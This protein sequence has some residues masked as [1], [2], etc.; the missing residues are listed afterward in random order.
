MMTDQQPSLSPQDLRKNFERLQ[1]ELTVVQNE[2]D[3][4]LTVWRTILMSERQEFKNILE[5]HEKN[6]EREE[7]QWQKDRM[8]YEEKIQQLES[9]FTQQQQATE[10]NAVRALNELDTAWQ[11][12]RDRWQQ[13]LA[14]QVKETREQLEAQAASHQRLEQRA[15]ELSLENE[16]IVARQAET[17]AAYGGQEQQWA[18]RVTLLE[19][20]IANW[21]AEKTSW[22]QSLTERL[23]ETQNQ[24]SEWTTERAEKDALIQQLQEEIVILE[25][26]VRE[27]EHTRQS[28]DHEL[29][30]YISTLETQIASLQ[31]FIQHVIPPA[32]PL[33]RKTDPVA[34]LSALG[35][36]LP[37]AR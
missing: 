5:E 34:P 10:K 28:Q 35:P 3:Q 9:F 2:L 33:R 27:S 8:A 22:Q 19:A 24:K 6:W 1:A 15:A 37:R 25:Q 29:E 36:T 30:T 31:D 21:E 4:A 11:Q 16:R 12:E 32:H 20:Q 17:Q 14:Q 18:E 26:R 23:N 13:T 7:N